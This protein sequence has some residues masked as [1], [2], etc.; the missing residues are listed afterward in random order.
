MKHL[1]AIILALSITLL[2]CNGITT[3]GSGIIK[4][5]DRDVQSF[6]SVKVRGAFDVIIR[7]GSSYRVRIIGDDNIVPLIKTRIRHETL[8]IYSDKDLSLRNRITIKIE[9]PELS[10]LESEGASNITVKDYQGSSLSIDASG[11]GRIILEGKTDDLDLELSGAVN[12]DSEKLIAQNVVVEISGA[13][14]AEVYSAESIQAEISGVGSIVYHGSPSHV[15]KS[16]SGLGTIKGVN[17]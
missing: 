10:A 9:T 12:V 6:S 13:S 17:K 2:G 8:D 1:S 5:D 15:H 11:A 16:I 14:N 7:P 4:N 3:R